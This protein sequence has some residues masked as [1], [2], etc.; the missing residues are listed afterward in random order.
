[1]NIKCSDAI[2]QSLLSCPIFCIIRHLMTL[3]A[4]AKPFLHALDAETAHNLAIKALRCA[5][6]YVPR[7]KVDT[8]LTTTV[9]GINFPSPVG[10]AA[11]FDKNAECYR[12]TLRQ[13]F[14]F[15]EV[16]TITTRP[17]AGNPKPRLFRLVEDNAVINRMGFNNGGMEVA[18]S[19]LIRHTLSEGIVGVNIGKNKETETALD[20]YLL[21]LNRLYPLADYITVNISSPNTPGLRDLQHKN[22]LMALVSGVFKQR[23]ALMAAHGLKPIL[24]KIAP[25]LDASACADISE[26]AREVGVDGLIVSNTTIARPASL[27]SANAAEAGGLSG[28]PL[29]HSSTDILR[30][31][32]R[33]TE[34]KIPLIGVGGIA[35]AEDAIE[36]IKAGASLVQLYSALVYQGFA[37]VDDINRGILAEMQKLGLNSVQEMV[38]IS[39]R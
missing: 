38:G 32:Y 12:A 6:C 14:G 34:G 33:L 39:H 23:E 30:T 18:A 25:D 27:Q 16:G 11:G 15:V 1:M 8:R 3:Y 19:N 21:V 36:K 24:V 20:D 22:A 35:S 4:L 10:L 26:V 2:Y 13:G 28:T 7:V 29:M 37:L 5:G 17:Q 9:M 31:M